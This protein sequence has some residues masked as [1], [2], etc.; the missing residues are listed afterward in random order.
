MEIALQ[1]PQCGAPVS[2]DESDRLLACAYCR[3][4]LLPRS[5]RFFRYYFPLPET[6]PS[7]DRD[8][9][10]L[11]YWRT[12]GMF[13]TCTAAYSVEGR[14]VDTSF[15]ALNRPGIPE[16][17]GLR[18]QA[19]KLRFVTPEMT[20]HLIPKDLVFQEMCL[21]PED[22]VF[23]S[24]SD[25]GRCDNDFLRAFVGDVISL[26]YSPV[27]FE[28][29]T[30]FDAI[31][32][33]PMV[34]VRGVRELLPARPDADGEGTVKFLP[35]LCPNCGW[36]LIAGKQSSVLLCNRC[37]AAWVASGQS[38]EQM[39]Y[40]V[41][42]NKA[43]SGASEYLPF[44]QIEA[45][46]KGAKLDS[47]ADLVRFANLPKV[48]RKEW[49]E[50]PFFFWVPAFKASPQA[51]LRVAQQITLAQPQE[52]FDSLLPE[53][54]IHPVTMSLSEAGQALTILL[55]E[56]ATRKK[57][58][59]PSLSSVSAAVKKAR[60]VF[61]PALPTMTE[62]VVCGLPCAIQKNTLRIAGS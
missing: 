6:S 35:A 30:M 46:V 43:V 55:A 36:E 2:L 5:D 32:G 9:F 29:D 39:E 8:L 59:F 21:T 47:Y 20:D 42:S 25:P 57:F 52:T 13:F 51:F 53:T 60:L 3:V 15:A 22:R 23:Q 10:Y 26:V 50:Q 16:S 24:Q 33:R 40:A 19:L 7:K 44:W 4:R 37:N 18:T 28:G 11:P 61:F 14:M 45:A 38:L 27:Y 31:L 58:F 54:T 49:E 1:C 62:L 12:K 41:V 56:I 34:P 48:V 17:L